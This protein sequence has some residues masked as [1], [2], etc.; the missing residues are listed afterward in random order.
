MGATYH[1]VFPAL[2]DRTMRQ[3]GGPAKVVRLYVLTCSHRLSEGLY[4]LPVGIIQHDTGLEP[5]HVDQAL[6]ELADARL[7]DYDPDA[8][9][10]LDRTAL[11]FAPLKNGVDRDTGE[12]RVDKRIAGAVRKLEHVPQTPLMAELYRLAVQHSPDLAA[13]LAVEWPVLADDEGPTRPPVD[14]Q[15]PSEPLASPLGAPP[16]GRVE[17]SRVKS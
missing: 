13:A 5:Q 2:W 4:H 3:L 9:V 11:K 6:R 10:V 12:V 14:N 8:E 16:K 1:P 17:L 7:I 15:A